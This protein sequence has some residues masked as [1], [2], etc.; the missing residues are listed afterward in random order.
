MR[1]IACSSPPTPGRSTS[2]GSRSTATCYH[3]E[4]RALLER[5]RAADAETVRRAGEGRFELRA[6]LEALMDAQG[7]DL[8]LSPPAPGPP[9]L[10]LGSTGD[11][12]MNLPWTYAGLPA[13]TLPAGRDGEGLPHGIQLCA[14]GGADEELLAWGHFVADCLQ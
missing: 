12:V 2:A 8:W 13:L 1:G 14:R 4:T 11:P 9:P 6:Q 10:G 5:G 3:G 7:I